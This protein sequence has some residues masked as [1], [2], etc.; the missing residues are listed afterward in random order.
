MESMA[1]LMIVIISLTAFLSFLAFSM[2]HE[3]A[4]NNEIPLNIL[5]DVR[6][7]NGEIEADIEEKM[8]VSAETNGYAGMRVI[9]SAGGIYDSKLTLNVGC[10]DSD[11]IDTRTGTIIVRT[12]DGRSVPVNYTVAVWS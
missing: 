8:L 1:A 3:N 12:D 10:Q 9:L 2:S 7:V 11:V 4:M 6:I 5:N